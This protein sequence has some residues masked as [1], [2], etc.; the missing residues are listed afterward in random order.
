VLLAG[1]QVARK[2]ES[3]PVRTQV[4]EGLSY[5]RTALLCFGVSQQPYGQAPLLRSRM[6]H[7]PA[8]ESLSWGPQGDSSP[9]CNLL[10]E[11][12]ETQV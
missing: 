12:V 5:C 8:Q 4:L 1:H 3:N 6:Y 11:G 9:D 7:V 2:R 10:Q